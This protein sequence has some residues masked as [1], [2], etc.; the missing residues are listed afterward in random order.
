MAEYINTRDIYDPDGTDELNIDLNGLEYLLKALRSIGRPDL[1]K[2]AQDI[3]YLTLI[4]TYDPQ[5]YPG[6]PEWLALEINHTKS[7]LKLALLRCSSPSNW[8]CKWGKLIMKIVI[9]YL[10][11][12]ILR[13]L[14]RSQEQINILLYLVE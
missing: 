4:Q 13:T 14:T 7:R 8:I 6:G 9:N 11:G 1:A 5:T 2:I 12:S 10:T 3:C